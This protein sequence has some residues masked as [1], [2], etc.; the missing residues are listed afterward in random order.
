[1]IAPP[2]RWSF[3]HLGVERPTAPAQDADHYL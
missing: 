1:L 3:G 2:L